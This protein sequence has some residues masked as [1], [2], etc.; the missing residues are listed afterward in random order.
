MQLELRVQAMCRVK[1]SEENETRK[2]NAQTSG[3]TEQN[4]FRRFS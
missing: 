3:G 1:R 2:N 4:P